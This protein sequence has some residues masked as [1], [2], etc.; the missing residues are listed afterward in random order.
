MQA[1]PLSFL[2]CL[3]FVCFGFFVFVLV[4][5]QISPFSGRMTSLGLNVFSVLT[6][7]KMQHALKILP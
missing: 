2:V 4:F 6:R 3:L 7:N 1:E 5:I